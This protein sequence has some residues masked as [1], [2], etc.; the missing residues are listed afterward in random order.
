MHRRVPN[1]A[2]RHVTLLVPGFSDPLPC[3]EQSSRAVL[4]ALAESLDLGHAEWL[5]SRGDRVEP[6]AGDGT[7][8]GL[9]W[10]HFGLARPAQGHW[11]A[12]PV[13]Y[14][15]DGGD[16][17]ERWIMR[18]DPV[19]LRPDRGELLLFDASAFAL[20]RAEAQALAEALNTYFEPEPWRLEALHPER[21]Y[22]SLDRPP[23]MTTRAL[24][25]VLGG[26]ISRGLP[27]GEEAPHWRTVLNEAQMVLHAAAVNEERETRG[28]P[29]I[30]SVWFWGGGRLPA[31]PDAGWDFVWADDALSR[32]LA[33]L[34]GV[35]CSAL[36]EDGR[37]WLQ[38]H[39]GHGRHLIVL[40]AGS[41][42]SRLQDVEGWRGFVSVVNRSW[43][44]PLLDAL[45]SGDLIS[46]SLVPG[47]KVELRAT[48]SSSRRLWR[49]R[50][51]WSDVMAECSAQST[52][53][54]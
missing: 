4:D 19:H 50:R 52:S 28:Q 11:P 18:A 16:P 9:R 34:S 39:R 15:A 41:A 42:L 45:R 36:P 13:T 37:A 29:P 14:L 7:V 23:A 33:G 26:P 27:Y 12:G 54:P 8:E 24:S 25:S 17:G 20:T 51:R 44:G 5:A 38:A 48:R 22:V 30:N 43:I 35:P 2:P 6:V 10:S 49:R 32:G 1:P 53:E 31:A 21:W 47:T 3:P 46:L 40:D